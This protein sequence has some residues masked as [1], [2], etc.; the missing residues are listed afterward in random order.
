MLVI[1][2]SQRETGSSIKGW[3]RMQTTT[4]P[5]KKNNSGSV[6]IF[7]R[8]ILKTIILKH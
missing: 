8:R 6:I 2:G 5:T 1:P 7:D 3:T 4:V